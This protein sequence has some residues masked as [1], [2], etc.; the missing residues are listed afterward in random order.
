M[1]EDW[2]ALIKR[3]DREIDELK[4]RNE[5]LTA[6]LMKREEENANL[7]QQLQRATE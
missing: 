2:E 1:Q 3:K 5:I 6:S 7:R 4:E